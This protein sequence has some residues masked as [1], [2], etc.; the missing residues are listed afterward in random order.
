MMLLCHG[1]DPDIVG[2]GLLPELHSA[3]DFHIRQHTNAGNIAFKYLI[4]AKTQAFLVTAELVQAVFRGKTVRDPGKDP[5]GAVMD[6]HDL[7]LILMKVHR[8][9]E[10]IVAE[11]GGMACR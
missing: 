2:S 3:Q 8:H 6:L 7:M 9:V 10:E 1:L 11:R 4:Y 5:A